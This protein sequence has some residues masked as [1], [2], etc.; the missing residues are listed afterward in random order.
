MTKKNFTVNVYHII[1][2]I[3]FTIVSFLY[4]NGCE[5]NTCIFQGNGF[6]F[7][8]YNKNFSLTFFFVDVVFWWIVYI[9]FGILFH[10]SLKI[11]NK[12]DLFKK[13]HYYLV[14]I[15]VT[16]LTALNYTV[17]GDLL[18]LF[19]GRGL[20]IPYYNSH[21]YWPFFLTDVVFWWG[22]YVLILG[23][24]KIIKSKKTHLKK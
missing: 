3:A 8:F 4:V 14:P 22:L 18:C 15:F 2:P 5:D 13:I 16:I 1:I 9:V 12:N 19:G 6:P 17:C 23:L 11:I 10:L 24:I 21:M 20:P 7:A